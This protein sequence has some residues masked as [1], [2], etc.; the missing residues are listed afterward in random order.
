M[1]QEMSNTIDHQRI[2]D[3]KYAQ[4]NTHADYHGDEDLVSYIG[5]APKSGM[6]LDVACG[7]GRNSFILAEHGLD[8]ICMDFSAKGL[9]YLKQHRANQA[10]SKKLHPIQADLTKI[11]L[12]NNCFDLVIVIRY[13]D[14][15]AF[16]SY[17][18]ALK[19]DGLLFFKAFNL[20][21]LK[22]KPGFNPDY[23][24]KPGE[25]ITQF[26]DQ[27]ILK[28]NDAKELSDFES[29]ILIKKTT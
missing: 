23:L 22:R 20:N 11:P 18:N 4:R 25:L 7:T 5:Y 27:Q 8:V 15:L 24:L 29:F 6:A 26:N 1:W 28:T 2:W 19:T 10:A 14:R 13:L 12:P 16:S 17:I 3:E 21:H 9:A